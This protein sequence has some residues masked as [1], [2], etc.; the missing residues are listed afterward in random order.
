MFHI[1]YLVFDVTK[2]VQATFTQQ[3][4]VLNSSSNCT[5]A[6]FTLLEKCIQHLKC[7]I[8]VSIYHWRLIQSS[9]RLLC[10]LYSNEVIHEVLRFLRKCGSLLSNRVQTTHEIHVIFALAASFNYMSE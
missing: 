10:V 8:E 4:A 5:K 2:D 1:I 6:L 9:W 3:L 7:G